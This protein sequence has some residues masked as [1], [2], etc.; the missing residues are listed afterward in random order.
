MPVSITLPA[1]SVTSG[2]TYANQVNTALTTLAAATHTGGSNGDKWTAASLNIDGNVSWGGYS[3]TSLKATTYT[4]QTALATANSV[5]VKNDGNLWFTN[6]SGSSVQITSGGT[7][8]TSALI[9]SVYAQL[10]LAANLVIASTDTYTQYLINT[11]SARTITLPGASAVGAGRYYIFTDASGSGRT[12]NITI[13][14]AGS[15]TI[16]GAT[17]YTIAENYGTITLVSDGTSKW[18]VIGV[19]MAGDL[20]GTKTSPTVTAVTG[21]SGTAAIRCSTVAFDSTTT[22]VITTTSLGGGVT[23]DGA[24]MTIQGQAVTNATTG[25]AGGAIMIKSGATAAA[26]YPGQIQMALGTFNSVTTGLEIMYAKTTSVLSARKIVSFFYD[27]S[28]LDSTHGNAIY[29]HNTTAA[30]T[31]GYG[32]GGL[33]YVES[34]ALKYKGGAGTA[35]TI[36]AA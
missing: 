7:L 16:E 8:N 3:V 20:A 31:A 19:R 27:G 26:S 30:P 2:P 6:G 5:W 11:A 15:D 32:G 36:A 29:I 17:S 12:N 25:G 24:L 13:N 35:T 18:S 22:P 34:G 23:S 4:Q 9:T 21:S 1:T 28:A 10:A 33:L 14:R